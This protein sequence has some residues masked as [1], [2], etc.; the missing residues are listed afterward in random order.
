[1]ASPAASREAASPNRHQHERTVFFCCHEPVWPLTGGSTNGNLAILHELRDAGLKP[2]AVTPFNGSY[3]TARRSIGV[4]LW[5][6]RP[7]LMH[8]SAS[9][10]TIRY[11]I[12]SVIYFFGLLHYIRREKPV[13]LICRNTVLALPVW[14]AGKLHGIPT[15]IVLADLLSYFFWTR[16]ARPPLWQRFFQHF[17]CKLAAL[18]DRIF[19][20]TSVMADEIAGH[21]GQK[22]RSRICVTRDGVHDRFLHITDADR[23]AAGTIRAEI[24]GESPL[25]V[26]YGTLELHHGMEE[27]FE[28]V[29]ILLERAP[30]FHVLIIG[31]GP[32]QPML[33]RSPLGRHPRVH[34]RDFLPHEPLIR[35]ALAADVGMIPYPAIPSTHMIYTFKFLEYRCLGLPVVAFPLETLRREFGNHPAL[36]LVETVNNYS[37]AVIALGKAGER[38]P[39]ESDFAESFSWRHVAAPLVEE[40]LGNGAR[41]SMQSNAHEFAGVKSTPTKQDHLE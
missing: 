14:A 22:V 32:C 19:V 36:R 11:A 31:G 4:R 41:V 9:F 39:I 38:F 8:R 30:D 10:R 40:A 12:F 33:L 25:A 13:Q 35:H 6:V 3:R 17:E 27:L 7:F 16:P 15:A 5:P 26:F 28:I 37:N 2:V 1:M 29:P 23:A 21:V 34:L 24:C 18:H 20:V